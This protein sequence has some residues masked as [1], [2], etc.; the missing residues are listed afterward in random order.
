MGPAIVGT[1]IITFVA[2][3][4]A[5][6]LGILGAVYLNEYGHNSRFARLVRFMATVMTGVPSIV[7]GLFI[8]VSFTVKF[9]TNGLQGFGGSLALAA[10]MLPVIIRSSKRCSSSCR[11]ICA[12][13]VWASADEEPHDPH[14]CVAGGATGRRVGMPAGSGP[15]SR[16]DGTAHL[17]DRRHNVAQSESVQRADGRV[18]MGDLHER[19]ITV[20]GCQR[21]RLGAALTLIILAFLFT[22][23]ARIVS[24]RFAL[25]R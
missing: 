12:K 3:L 25:K 21:A 1:L 6:P 24:S 23:I 11:L 22:L 14:G 19:A 15:S 4:I 5:V 8:Y 17:H 10:L 13:R 20:R 7:M 18:A 2:T 16:R 9:G